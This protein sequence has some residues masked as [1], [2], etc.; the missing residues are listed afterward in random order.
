MK[1]ETEESKKAPQLLVVLVAP[2][3]LPLAPSWIKDQ[4]FLRDQHQIE[5]FEP[6]VKRCQEQTSERALLQ[7]SSLRSS[8]ILLSCVTSS[9]FNPFLFLTSSNTASSCTSS[10][11]TLTGTLFRAHMVMMIVVMV[12]KWLWRTQPPLYDNRGDADG[13]W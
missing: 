7:C 5:S 4:L 13:S 9:G 12:M 8:L 1:Q 6:S 10:S 11:T 2:K 3:A